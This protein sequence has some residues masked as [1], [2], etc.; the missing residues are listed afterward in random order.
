MQ[1][2]RPCTSQ[3]L[4]TFQ[5]FEFTVVAMTIVN[6]YIRLWPG[7]LSRGAE[8]ATARAPSIMFLEGNCP[9]KIISH[10]M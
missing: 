1:F 4:A 2:D 6:M 9:S 8:G 3:L 10:V 5:N 7:R